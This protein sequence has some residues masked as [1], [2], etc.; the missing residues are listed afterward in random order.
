MQQTSEHEDKDD[1]WHGTS[2]I[3]S[4]MEMGNGMELVD[5]LRPMLGP[6]LDD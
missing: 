1:T 5:R 3:T 2:H 4:H 6:G